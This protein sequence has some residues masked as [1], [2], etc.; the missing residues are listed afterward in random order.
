MRGAARIIAVLI[1]AV[2]CW[3]Q[4]MAQP[5]VTGRASVIDGDT[6]EIA[7]VRIR[8]HGIDAVESAQQCSKNGA[9]YPCG[10]Q[11]AN[12]LASFLGQRTVNCT[13]KDTDRYG[14]MVAECKVSGE[15][16]NAW[17]VSSG[18]AMA[19]I[20][21]GGAIYLAQQNAAKAAKR[22]IWAGTFQAPWDYRRNPSNPPTAGTPRPSSNPG[23]SSKGGDKNCS[24]FA[25]YSEA[26]AFFR[27]AG[28]GDPHGLDRDKDGIPCE[29]LPGAP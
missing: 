8:L 7:G 20:E 23:T 19:Y 11:A 21:Y 18:W 15:N 2:A 12:A 26:L 10:R 17:L 27:S 6:L 22:G 28:P 4:T 5:S 29:S 13:R 14:R 24:D 9:A 3:G 1:W 25:T 16:I